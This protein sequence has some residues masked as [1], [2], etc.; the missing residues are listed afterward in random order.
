MLLDTSHPM[1]RPEL[2]RGLDRARKILQ[3]QGKFC[4]QVGQEYSTGFARKQLSKMRMKMAEHNEK[5]LKI[6]Y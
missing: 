6:I 2:E 3:S 5:A 4:L 1:V